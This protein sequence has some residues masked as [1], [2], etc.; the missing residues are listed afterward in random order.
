MKTAFLLSWVETFKNYFEEQTGRTLA[1]YTGIYF[2]KEYNNFR[3]PGSGYPLADA[4]LW[5]A[6]YPKASQKK[7]TVPPDLGSWTR[8][9]VWQYTDRG[10]VKGIEGKVDLNRGIPE[11]LTA[12]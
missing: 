1:I 2:I 5:I 3:H 9:T 10:K 4:P 8:W 11:L 7:T 12:T 6:F